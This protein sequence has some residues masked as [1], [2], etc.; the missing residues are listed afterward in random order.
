MM[1]LSSHQELDCIQYMNLLLSVVGGYTG[2]TA[3]KVFLKKQEFF[4]KT[5]E[6]IY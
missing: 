3:I 4:L 6:A 5:S 1:S 2:E